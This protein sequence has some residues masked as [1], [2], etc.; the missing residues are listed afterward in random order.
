MAVCSALAGYIPVHYANSSA[1]HQALNI[2]LLSARPS[3]RIHSNRTDITA[4][5]KTRDGERRSTTISGFVPVL[6]FVYPV[7]RVL[8]TVVAPFV[9]VA[10]ILYAYYLI[11]A[12]KVRTPLHPRAL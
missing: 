10:A 2:D 12:H 9:A 11:D 8:V 3:V 6:S 7:L 1:L 4:T 5:T